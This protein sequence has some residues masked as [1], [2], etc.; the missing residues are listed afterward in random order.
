MFEERRVPAQCLQPRSGPIERQID[1]LGHAERQH[2]AEDQRNQ[3]DRRGDGARQEQRKQ[4]PDGCRERV[5]DDPERQIEE[6]RRVH[7]PDGADRKVDVR[8]DEG[9]LLG[10]RHERIDLTLP[11]VARQHAVRG[12]LLTPVVH[13]RELRHGSLPDA[14]D[15][16]LRGRQQPGCQL[17]ASTGGRRGPEPLK[18]RGAAEQIEVERERVM[19]H[20]NGRRCVGRR[21][22]IPAPLDSGERALAGDAQRVVPR[23]ALFHAR[24]PDDQPA[25]HREEEGRD[26]EPQGI[27]AARQRP[28]QPRGRSEKHGEPHARDATRAAELG[29]AAAAVLRG[30]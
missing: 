4:D 2:Q 10:P 15:I 17:R 14:N 1:P 27:R 12:E 20:I 18:Q 23:G 5:H 7:S 24:V 22:I 21:Q 30:P 26:A 25:K 11:R 13:R 28:D 3:P 8:N 16:R 6:N 19:G 29:V 9:P